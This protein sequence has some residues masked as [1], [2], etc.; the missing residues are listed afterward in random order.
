MVISVRN[1]VLP[2][3][4]SIVTNFTSVRQMSATVKSTD[5]VKSLLYKEYGEPVD[6][7][8]VTTQSIDQPE[9]NQVSQLK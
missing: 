7:L 5:F 4:R 2:L 8:H 9:N 1:L 6:V 3:S